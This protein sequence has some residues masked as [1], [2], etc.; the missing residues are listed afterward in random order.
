MNP[1]VILL[2]LAVLTLLFVVV[3]VG[4]AVYA[5]WRRPIRLAC[6]RTG[7]EAQLSVAALGAAVRA[8]LG[9]DAPE[10]ARCSLWPVVS[11]CK[12]ECLAAPATTWRVVPQGT[13]PPRSHRT[14]GVH[15]I[16]VPLDG[17]KGSESAL[18]TAACLARA[19]DATL[20][21]VRVVAPVEAVTSDDGRQTIAFS[22]QETDRVEFETRTY[23]NQVARR[24]PGV[25]VESAVRFGDPVERIVDEA[26]ACG[27]DLI[28]L[29]GRRRGALARMFRGSFVARLRR[30]TR[31][32]TLV[33]YDGEV[34]AAA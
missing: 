24:L 9:R 15:V 28:A 11:T 2:G 27:A 12:Q 31:I 34:A 5:A 22:D 21:L 23:L 17:S 8:T 4:W 14:P 16:L 6:P 13:P 29:A 1:W 33:V 20:R 26:E 19:Y 10:V 32:P 18:D 30:A 3:P 25:K 7:T